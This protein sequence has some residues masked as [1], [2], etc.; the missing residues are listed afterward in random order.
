M[1]NVG[2]YRGQ[3]KAPKRLGMN[4]SVELRAGIYA[5]WEKYKAR[6][7]PLPCAVV[8]GCPPVVSYA[9]V[10]KLANDLDELA[11]AGAIAG[12]PINVVRCKTVDLLVPAEAEIVIEGLIN[13]EML[14]PEAP[15][16][17]SHGY[18]NLQEYNAFMDVTAITRRRHPILTSFISQVT[19][20]ESSVIRRVAMEPVFQHYLKSVLSIRGVKR[21]AM[22]EPLTSLY[23]VIAIQFARGT[24][25]SEIWRALH[26]AASLHRFAGKWI[27][28]VDEDIEPEN[29]DALLWAMSYRCQPQYD[30]KLM[31]H[32][33]PGHGP[34]GPHDD[35]ETAAVLINAT[36][37]GTFA[38]V[39]LPKR[40]FME[41]AKA[42]WER[43][44]LPPLTPESPWHGYDLGHWP[45]ELARQAQMATDSDYFSLGQAMSNERR[46]DVA[47]NEPVK[48]DDEPD[49]PK[50]PA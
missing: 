36:L 6:G 40:E 14:E 16:G 32:K 34:R 47:M 46:R 7:E 33:D 45:R 27:I 4:P 49:Q 18:V 15:F 23:A 22:H 37:K 35:G 50:K 13:T 30:L 5:H 10:Q 31:P 41:N 20:S 8:V 44:G 17:E 21:V 3:L 19:P 42:I 28:A 48:R 39:A 29:A 9:S 12:G 26:G 11:V 24:P 38:P 2:N 43:L 25:E 1:Q